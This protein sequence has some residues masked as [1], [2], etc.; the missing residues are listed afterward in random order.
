MSSNSSD[1]YDIGDDFFDYIPPLEQLNLHEY[2]FIEIKPVKFD[3]AK[4]SDGLE[5]HV[6]TNMNYPKI[7][8][9]VVKVLCVPGGWIYEVGGK[10]V[11]VPR[12]AQ[13]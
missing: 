10:G 9:P 13:L 1:V 7:N 12:P 6:K 8:P 11:F 2:T 4:T 3:V 5:K